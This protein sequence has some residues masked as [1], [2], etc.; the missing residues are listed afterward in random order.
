MYQ[1][2]QTYAV[3][4]PPEDLAMFATLGPSM[5]AVQGAVEKASAE[6]DANVD[7]FCAFLQRDIK[8]LNQEV[9]AVKEK[10]HVRETAPL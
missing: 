8:E 7:K 6:R 1:L 10:A 2:I 5:T 4:T 9:K 3:P